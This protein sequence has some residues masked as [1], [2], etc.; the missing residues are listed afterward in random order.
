[1]MDEFPNVEL[2]DLEGE[3]SALLPCDNEGLL[4]AYKLDRAF[5]ALRDAGPA[6]DALLLVGHRRDRDLHKGWL[7]K[8]MKARLNVQRETEDAEL[9][10]RQ[11]DWIYV[12]GS[13]SGG[14]DGVLAPERSFVAR[15]AERAVRPSVTS[16]SSA[17]IEIEIAN[18][19]FLVHRAVNDA[20][21]RSSLTVMPLAPHAANTFVL[22]TLEEGYTARAAWAPRLQKDDYPIRVDGLVFLADGS[23]LLGLRFPMTADGHPLLVRIEDLGRCFAENGTL[24]ASIAGYIANAGS[25]ERPVGIR[26]LQRTG[27]GDHDRQAINV[28][29]G[30]LGSPGHRDA[31][32]HDYPGSEKAPCRHWCIE[33]PMGRAAGE[34]LEAELVR[35][36][37]K[38][39]VEGFAQDAEAHWHYL[40]RA[41]GE[42]FIVLG[43]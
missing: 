41:S 29:T 27:A 3:A 13:Q 37:D 19:P 20:L 42:S 5:W 16:V 11:G 28:L 35:Q 18:R 14:A 31:L 4:A 24:T 7:V 32:A 33:L 10:A 34:G 38:H 15:F 1:M 22:P 2:K 43:D 39:N 8:A 9:L 36:F 6:E 12:L 21:K 26:A 40:S 23:A 30:P 17:R 25:A